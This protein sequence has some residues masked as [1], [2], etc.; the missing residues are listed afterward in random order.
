MSFDMQMILPTLPLL[1]DSEAI[2]LTFQG[3]AESNMREE[4]N[5]QPLRKS[6]RPSPPLRPRAKTS[7]IDSHLSLDTALAEETPKSCCHS[8]SA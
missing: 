4:Q 5:K 3:T 8:S 1:R 6:S 7:R 2:L